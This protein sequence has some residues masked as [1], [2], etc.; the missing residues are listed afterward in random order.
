MFSF[1]LSTQISM[2]PVS[3]PTFF[4]KWLLHIL[5]L[6]MFY[7][8]I[9]I[10]A[11]YKVNISICFWCTAVMADLKSYNIWNHYTPNP[12]FSSFQVKIIYSL[13]ASVKTKESFSPASSCHPDLLVDKKSSSANYIIGL[14]C[15]ELR[16]DISLDLCPNLFSWLKCTLVISVWFIEAARI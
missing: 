4:D 12:L 2:S 6:K 13:F 5:P 8:L 15:S 16:H 9:S 10:N 3:V 11:R 14:W 1:S 7:A